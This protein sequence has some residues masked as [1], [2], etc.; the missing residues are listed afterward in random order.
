MQINIGDHKSPEAGY[1]PVPVQLRNQL[2]WACTRARTIA[3]TIPDANKYFLH[4]PKRRSLTGLLAHRT[5]AAGRG[6]SEAELACGL[7][8]KSEQVAGDDPY[9]PYNPNTIG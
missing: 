6:S 7:G 2:N 9:T 5:I 1:L 8:R 4:L 3:G